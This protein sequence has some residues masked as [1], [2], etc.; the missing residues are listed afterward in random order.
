MTPTTSL[1][2][3]DLSGLFWAIVAMGQAESRSVFDN[4]LTQNHVE[5][6]LVDR[7][8]QLNLVPMALATVVLLDGSPDQ[9]R[10]VYN[11]LR[12]GLE[13]WTISPDRIANLGQRQ[14]HLGD[15]R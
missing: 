8:G 6:A 13:P 7:V 10:V 2:L 3:I 5:Y 14:Q 9:L 12:D 4:L 11:S 15:V 1:S